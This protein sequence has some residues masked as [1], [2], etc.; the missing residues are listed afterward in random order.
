MKNEK[1]AEAAR[2]V[3][4]CIVQQEYNI[5]VRPCCCDLTASVCLFVCLPIIFLIYPYKFCLLSRKCPEILGKAEK[6]RWEDIVYHFL[7][8]GQLKVSAELH[9]LDIVAVYKQ[10]YIG[11]GGHAISVSNF[12]VMLKPRISCFCPILAFMEEIS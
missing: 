12:W 4:M 2:S 9:V 8:A 7:Q 6:K 10:H 5:M 11:R 1:F 3:R